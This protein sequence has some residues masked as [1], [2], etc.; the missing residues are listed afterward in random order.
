MSRPV[1]AGLARFT[2]AVLGFSHF[3][4]PT[5]DAETRRTLRALVPFE[6][7]ELRRLIQEGFERKVGGSIV[8][9]WDP[10]RIASWM[11]LASPPA[12]IASIVC[13]FIGVPGFTVPILFL[14]G[15]V[16]FKIVLSRGRW[17]RLDD[18]RAL[19]FAL[20][21]KECLVRES[22]NETHFK[23][24]VEL[25]HL[26]RQQAYAE[27][28]TLEID[29][30]M[31]GCGPEEV[32]ALRLDRLRFERFGAVA[33]DQ[34]A[35]LRLEQAEAR[36]LQQEILDHFATIKLRLRTADTEAVLAHA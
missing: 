17:H 18:Q 27:S 19:D 36:R 29:R 10:K 25:R 2:N 14:V 13:A 30:Y 5:V 9:V 26:R 34:I 4:P 22:Y 16:A 15:L 3:A 20:T 6:D 11:I 32:E 31:V 21:V 24:L 8:A 33:D 7:L 35:Q 23:S 1:Q 28:M 12:I